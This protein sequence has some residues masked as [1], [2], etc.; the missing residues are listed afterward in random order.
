MIIVYICLYFSF[1]IPL[2]S[3]FSL[4]FVCY[5]SHVLLFSLQCFH[6]IFISLVLLLVR[7]LLLQ[8]FTLPR[9]YLPTGFIFYSIEIF[10]SDYLF[11]SFCSFMK[12]PVSLSFE[13]SGRYIFHLLATVFLFYICFCWH[14]SFAICILSAFLF[15]FFPLWH[16]CI[17]LLLIPF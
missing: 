9:P 17:G 15:S 10:F 8:L 4:Y 2:D 5:L 12:Q 3:L 14:F 6:Q 7:Q 1:K 13:H 11:F 16:Y